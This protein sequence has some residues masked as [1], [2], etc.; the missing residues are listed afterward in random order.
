MFNPKTTKG[1]WIID[2]GIIKSLDNEV[3]ANANQTHIYNAKA[4]V[5]V[6]ELLEVYK[7]AK[8]YMT[9]HKEED[10]T[11]CRINLDIA[12]EKLEERHCK[13]IKDVENNER[14]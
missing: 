3:I 5:A 9:F 13:S 4:I 6:P 7:A 8:E 14:V 10:H 12:I 1:K 11:R 2:D